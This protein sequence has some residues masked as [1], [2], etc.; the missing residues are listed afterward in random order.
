MKYMNPNN[1][2]KIITIFAIVSVVFVLLVNIV[3]LYTIDKLHITVESIYDHPLKVSNAA[4]LVQKSVIKIHRDM[5]DIVLSSTVKE[6][7]IFIDKVDTEE[8]VVYKTLQ[9]IEND[10]LGDK[11]VALEKETK[12]LFHQWKPI[13]DEVIRLIE[14]NRFEEAEFITKNKGAEHVKSL[15]ESAGL[16]YKYAHTK[17]NTFQKNAHETFLSFNR[18]IISLSVFTVAFFILFMLYI[19]NRIK[20]YLNVIR[21]NER[22]LR[23]FNKQYALAIEGTNDGL[24]DWNI[25]EGTIYFS[26]RWKEMLGYKDDE[27]KNEFETWE[28]R[29]HPDDLEDA[30]EEVAKAHANPEYEY[31]T[32]HRLRHK[33]GSWVWVLDRGKTFFNEKGEA[34]RMVGFHTDITKEKTQAAELHEQEEIMIAQSRHAAMGEMISMIAHQWRQPISVIAMDAN[35]IQADIELD[36][37]DNDELVEISK[38]I[39]KQT[40]ELSQTIDDFREFFKPN[41]HPDEVHI[42]RV[43][44][45]TLAIIGKSLKNNNISLAL[46]IDVS[47]KIKTFSRE[48]MQ[49]LI[50][51]IKNAK[52]AFID[53]DIDKQ[54]IKIQLI[55]YENSIKITVCDN[56]GGINKEIMDEIFNPYFTT[57]DEKNGTGL[58]LYMSKTIIEKHLKGTIIAFN[59]NSGVCFEIKL[60][61]DFE[62]KGNK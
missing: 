13:R 39:I 26:P 56:A 53:K 5:K 37:L 35:N 45:E 33:N 58:G 27:L 60:P 9:S 19:R 31:H 3:S 15:E 38:D 20:K 30:L 29:V 23:E 47:V 41:R 61:Y 24:W 22:R 42:K 28:S 44:D 46:D 1:E 55:S 16:L 43:I 2:G 8:K 62:K 10:I 6:R 49:V 32:V 12:E 57:K 50:N 34:I 36:L 51:I 40:Q 59:K 18:V 54:E 4:L 52:E 14:E 11:G 21:K 25:A 48:L 17:A 7:H